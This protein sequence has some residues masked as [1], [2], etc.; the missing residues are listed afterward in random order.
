MKLDSKKPYITPESV[1]KF[2]VFPLTTTSP[3]ARIQKP[4]WGYF[5]PYFNKEQSSNCVGYGLLRL[6][7]KD[8][9]ND[10][11]ETTLKVGVFVARVENSNM[12]YFALSVQQIP[13]EEFDKTF[14][15]KDKKMA[16]KTAHNHIFDLI[17]G[18]GV[19]FTID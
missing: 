18:L 14:K 13:E 7:I 9:N 10:I 17:S 4:N 19:N 6:E 5:M 12:H 16:D 8:R 1:I 3:K 11:I 2:G 15:E